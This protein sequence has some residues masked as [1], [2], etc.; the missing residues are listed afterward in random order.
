MILDHRRGGAV[1]VPVCEHRPAGIRDPAG[2]DVVPLRW[3]SF[4]TDIHLL[5]AVTVNAVDP[6][7]PV[8]LPIDVDRVEHS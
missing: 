4:L 8:F 3:R 7:D 2:R 5:I 1:P 6:E